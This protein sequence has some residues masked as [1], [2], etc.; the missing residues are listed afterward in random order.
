PQGRSGEEAEAWGRALL[1]E[2][3]GSASA[4]PRT[5]AER[6]S[7]ALRASLSAAVYLGRVCA[8][9]RVPGIREVAR[10]TGLN[11]KVVARAYRTLVEEGALV[12][13]DRSGVYVGRQ[14][15][16]EGP[17]TADAAWLAGVLA[18]S[19]LRGMRVTALP[20]LLRR[21]AASARL[22]CACVESDAGRRL[23]LCAEVGEPFGLECVALDPEALAGDEALARELG[24]TDLVV[25]TAYHAGRVRGLARALG[26]P[27][28]VVGAQ[29]GAEDGAPEPLPRLTPETA[30][31]IS[32]TL[33]MLNLE[34]ARADEAG[35]AAV[36]AG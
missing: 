18:E 36:Q 7:G 3:Q 23:A 35:G 33:V 16:R 4:E 27:L 29:P 26:K 14:E 25:T 10:A 5:S 15:W 21:S 8:G 31:S 30:R 11:H 13:R 24:G 20:E 2:L 17:A 1:A 32:E 19:W 34:Q 22:R 28:L 9:D 6:L 12:V